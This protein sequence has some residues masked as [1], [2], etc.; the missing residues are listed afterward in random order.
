MT[1]VPLAA[2]VD[3]LPLILC[4]PI[5]RRVDL[6]SVS[7]W[8]VTSRECDVRLIVDRQ[9]GS[10]TF[11]GDARTM[12]FG[13]RVW[14]AVVR[15]ESADTLPWSTMFTYDL[16][17]APEG[18]ADTFSL[19]SASASAELSYQG[20]DRPSFVTPARQARDLRILHGSCRKPHGSPPGDESRGDALPLI[21]RYLGWTANQ[22][23]RRPCQLYLAGDQIYADDVADALLFMIQD[24]VPALIGPETLPNRLPADPELAPGKRAEMT[25]RA[26]L[27]A[28]LNDPRYAKS[29]LMTFGE[30]L[31]MYLFVWS[32]AL[33]PSDDL[34]SAHVVA[35]GDQDYV[36]DASYFEDEIAAL[37]EFRLG[38]PA[39]RRAL[40]NIS[41]YMVFDDHD[42]TDDWNI[43]YDWAASVYSGW[44]LVAD[45]PV[46]KLAAD[47]FGAQVTA[48]PG[49]G[50]R[51]VLNALGAY[52]VCQAWGNTPDSPMFSTGGLLSAIAGWATS[53]S[54]DF[55]ED[56]EHLLLPPAADPLS[57]T[58]LAYP[59]DTRWTFVISL[60]DANWE[61]VFLDTRCRRA[62]PGA[63]DAE[64][65]PTPAALISTRRL[66]EQLEPLEGRDH[67]L[68]VSPAP[69]FGLQ[70][71]E[72]LQRGLARFP[73]WGWGLDFSYSKDFEAWSANPAAH[74]FL[75]Q[76]LAESDPS[77]RT[78]VFLSGDV[79]HGFSFSLRYKRVG[80]DPGSLTFVQFTSS[81]FKNTEWKTELLR[82]AE[83]LV[84]EG[85]L[86]LRTWRIS[87][88]DVAGSVSDSRAPTPG[89][90]VAPYWEG[91][92]L[93]LRDERTVVP[94]HSETGVLNHR[95]TGAIGS[96]SASRA[97]TARRVLATDSNR[98]VVDRNHFAEVR[99]TDNTVVQ[100]LYVDSAD[101]GWDADRLVQTNH[102][103][104][105]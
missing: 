84:E 40:A 91:E 34:P 103:A 49:L 79:H 18:S 102:V 15:A 82:H 16:E 13:N 92:L 41:T 30:Y 105:F 78:I 11:G 52:A 99:F 22:I 28:G 85:G 39:A 80:G 17:L 48:E 58:E 69:V 20:I 73:W 75:L 36:D 66:Q 19:T 100:A 88:G 104:S 47:N 26:G 97:L 53:G 23:Q 38:L 77:P 25:V 96:Q 3:S 62:W 61:V 55:L 54:P 87:G 74:Y 10:R 59:E 70:V 31:V 45:S 29:H 9:D 72:Q 81:P 43:F 27:S 68:V 93:S 95:P 83:N 90:L 57:G 46:G 89:G 7:V 60:E 24:A 4:G 8:V 51:I 86:L 76:T 1:W 71:V 2:R 63:S 98:I 33:W 32:D 6:T 101:L 14:I 44:G 5:L 64:D 94:L 21:D 37:A 12:R 35:G 65:L 67:L 42:V 56:C 50:R